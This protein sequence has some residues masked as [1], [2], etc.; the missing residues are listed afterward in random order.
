MRPECQDERLDLIYIE[1]ITLGSGR[2][3]RGGTREWG[4]NR[5]WFL[6]GDF[7]QEKKWPWG[8]A[9][10]GYEVLSECCY[11]GLSFSNQC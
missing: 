2:R 3:G 4:F 10:E 8:L 6:A 7:S 5:I 9:L 1:L 11:V